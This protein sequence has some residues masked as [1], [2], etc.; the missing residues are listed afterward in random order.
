[1]PIDYRDF[2]GDTVAVVRMPRICHER[3]VVLSVNNNT[4]GWAI[5]DFIT[6]RILENERA[7]PLQNRAQIESQVDP[8]FA[9]YPPF[10]NVTDQA[11][12]VK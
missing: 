10:Y 4:G 11:H 5:R 12:F 7:K 2:S 3:L 8:T 9:E 6:N 1:M